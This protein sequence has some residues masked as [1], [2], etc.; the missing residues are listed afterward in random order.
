MASPEQD[1]TLPR[2]WEWGLL[3]LG[4]VVGALFLLVAP[5][6]KPIWTDESISIA[7]G[8]RPLADILLGRATSPDALPLHP[9]LMHVTTVLFGDNLAAYRLASAL[10]AAF[11]LWF[12]Y[13]LGARYSRGAGL[14]ALWLAALSPGLILFDRMSRYHGLTA[15]L[16]T[17]SVWAALRVLDT[18]RRRDALLYGVTTFLMLMSYVLS[19]FVVAAQF[20][21]L[22]LHWKRD[23]RRALRLFAGMVLGCLAFAPFLLRNLLAATTGGMTETFVEDPTVGLG[24]R[25]FLVRFALPAYVF[26]VGETIYPWNWAVSVP[27]VGASVVAFCAG[28]WALRKKPDLMIPLAALCVVLLAALATSGKFGAS[29]TVGSMAKR[30]SFALPLFCVTLGIGVFSF[31]RVPIQAILAGILLLVSAISVRNYWAGEQFLNP[32]YTA[33]WRL[34]IEK[35]RHRQLDKDTLIVSRGELALQY[36]LQRS[37]PDARYADIRGEAKLKKVLAR[38]PARYVWIV[39]RD[40]GD[41]IAVGGFEEARDYLAANYARVATEGVLPRTATEARWL[42]RV[43]KRPAAPHYIEMELYDTATPARKEAP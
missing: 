4:L 41:R 27:G 43:F 5:E 18:G 26:C 15:L 1:K 37:L 9:L 39:G 16:V 8:Q 40:R 20:I 13:R 7:W 6:A 10:P 35:M 22:L 24:L 38:E 12:V 31:R 34:A 23:P 33:P 21:T 2:A 17:V 25:G 32:N 19:V 11:G 42:E 28:V 30:V 14:L 29:Q 3:G 36:Y